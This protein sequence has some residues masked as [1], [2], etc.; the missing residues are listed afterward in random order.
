MPV[1]HITQHGGIG[2]ANTP[3]SAPIGDVDGGVGPIRTARAQPKPTSRTAREAVLAI[4]GHT[5]KRAGQRKTKAKQAA[6]D[7]NATVQP[8]SGGVGPS[9]PEFAATYGYKSVVDSSE[10]SK[11]QVATDVW[12][13]VRLVGESSDRPQNGLG[14]E[15][16]GAR[17]MHRPSDVTDQDGKKKKTFVTC[18]Y[19]L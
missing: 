17:S 15:D 12:W 8:A 1:Q 10:P 16:A 9:G 18:R 2:P 11:G 7:R 3:R 6:A 13:F 19:C 4:P 5:R 14:P